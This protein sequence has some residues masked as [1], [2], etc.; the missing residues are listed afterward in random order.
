M[1]LAVGPH[2]TILLLSFTVPFLRRCITVAMDI[3]PVALI[4]QP[5]EISTELNAG[6]K[7]GTLPCCGTA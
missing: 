6:Y 2:W 5:G 3:F 4:A 7:R 1:L